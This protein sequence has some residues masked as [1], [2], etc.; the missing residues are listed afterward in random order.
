[1]C[2]CQQELEN[3]EAELQQRKQEVRQL[4]ANLQ[5]AE[6]IIVSYVL[7]C[8]NVAVQCNLQEL[9]VYKGRQKLDSISKAEKGTCIALLVEIVVTCAMQVLC[10]LRI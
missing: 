7:N 10:L 3:V 1:M 2:L 8:D 6:R 4:Q 5:E 9:A